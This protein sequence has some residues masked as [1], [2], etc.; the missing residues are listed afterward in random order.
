MTLANKLQLYL[1]ST[2]ITFVL[3]RNKKKKNDP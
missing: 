1:A 3:L 2:N